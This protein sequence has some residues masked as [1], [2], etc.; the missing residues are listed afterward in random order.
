MECS[1]GLRKEQIVTNF[2]VSTTEFFHHDK[3]CAKE[4]FRFRTTGQ[5]AF[6]DDHPN[7]INF[8]FAS[9]ELTVFV[10]EVIADFNK[11]SVC[12]FTN[13]IAAEAKVI[14]GLKCA[15]FNYNKDTQIPRVGDL[16]Y[17]IYSVDN[18]RLFYGQMTQE[19]DGSSAG[20][21]PNSYSLEF[22]IR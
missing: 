21:R 7:W 18:E 12:G 22:L 11:R 10:S 8:T 13:W 6:N 3:N 4:S 1:N 15:L 16:K 9:T 19:K 20:K 2:D 14:T 17:G 5:I